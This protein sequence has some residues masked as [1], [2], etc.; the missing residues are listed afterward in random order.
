MA[1]GLGCYPAVKLLKTFTAENSGLNLKLEKEPHFSSNCLI[2][3]RELSEQ[4]IQRGLIRFQ[5]PPE[6][7]PLYTI[8]ILTSIQVEYIR[9]KVL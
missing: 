3:I 7:F 1:T 5:S 4:I 8:F 6:I 2:K 9:V